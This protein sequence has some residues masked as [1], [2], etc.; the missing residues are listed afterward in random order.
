MS[1]SMNDRVALVITF[2]YLST[3]ILVLAADAYIIGSA[4]AFVLGEA[5]W[6]APLYIAAVLALAT[7][8]TC[9]A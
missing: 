5:A 8:S 7:G 2:T 6:A 3:I 1:K 9:A 4:I